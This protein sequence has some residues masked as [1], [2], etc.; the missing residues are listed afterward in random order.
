MRADAVREH[1]PALSQTPKAPRSTMTALLPVPTAPRN[2]ALSLLPALSPAAAKAI[3]TTPEE[4][5]RRWMAGLSPAAARNYTR[6]MRSFCSWALTDQD[7][8]PERALQLLVDAGCGPAHNMVM[9]WR[10]HLLETG[11]SSGTVAGQI[12]GISS[13]LKAC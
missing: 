11:L 1:R 7:A 13:L 9:Q 3:D 6:A 8:P 12:V 10:D 2:D 4:I 5:V